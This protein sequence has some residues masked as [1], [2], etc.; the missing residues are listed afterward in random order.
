MVGVVITDGSS[1]CCINDVGDIS[2]SMEY[3]SLTFC[4]RGGLLGCRRSRVRAEAA[5]WL[6]WRASEDWSWASVAVMEDECWVSMIPWNDGLRRMNRRIYSAAARN[7][8]ADAVVVIGEVVT[9]VFMG[10]M[11]VFGVIIFVR[12]V[13]STKVVVDILAVS[14]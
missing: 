4:H 8:A 10:I 5:P 7:A 13:V 6:W 9:V 1:L 2:S 12:D 3:S 11:S 14:V